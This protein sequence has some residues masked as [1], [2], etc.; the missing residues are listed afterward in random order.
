MKSISDNNFLQQNVSGKIVQIF[1]EQGQLNLYVNGEFYA[2]GDKIPSIVKTYNALQERPTI[3]I[4][5]N[6]FYI[7]E[8]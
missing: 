4:S 2:R 8:Q 7:V 6:D 1:R 3:R 5:V